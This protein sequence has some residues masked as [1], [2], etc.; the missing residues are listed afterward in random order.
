MVNTDNSGTD[1]VF[2]I[3]VPITVDQDTGINAIPSNDFEINYL[4]DYLLDINVYTS[5]PGYTMNTLFNNFSYIYCNLTSQ[6][7]SVAITNNITLS[8]LFNGIH[9]FIERGTAVND[10]LFNNHQFPP[11][12]EKIAQRF[13][14]IIAVKMFA[15]A[16]GVAAITTET[17]AKYDVDIPTQITKQMHTVFTTPAAISSFFR[18]YVGSTRFTE[19]SL[20]LASRDLDSFETYA[21]F[22]IAQTKIDI[23]IWFT[24]K[25]FDIQGR[26]VGTDSG[27]YAVDMFP[28]VAN[29]THTSSTTLGYDDFYK[30][31]H[32]VINPRTGEYNI[33]LLLSLH[34]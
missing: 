15:S 10:I 13:K 29:L 22:N 25:V 21:A 30:T 4:Y 20:N 26:A 2:F 16:E 9:T 34:D 23:P 31:Y 6:L 14:E 28:T 8:T 19:D 5:T 32:S 12:Q 1:Y 3:N 18:Q 24:G 17:S 33:S 11:E 7:Q 27:K